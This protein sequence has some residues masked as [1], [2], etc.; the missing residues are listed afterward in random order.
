MISDESEKTRVKI[1]GEE[2][3]NKVRKFVEEDE[4]EH[5]L[6]RDEE[7]RTKRKL[8]TI[9]QDRLRIMDERTQGML[10]QFRQQLKCDK[11][12]ESFQNTQLINEMIKL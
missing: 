7:V 4:L 1:A 5:Y 10:W 11:E 2:I 9:M 8:F 3:L 12:L 6:E